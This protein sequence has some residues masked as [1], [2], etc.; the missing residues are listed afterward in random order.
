MAEVEGVNTYRGAKAAAYAIAEKLQRRDEALRELLAYCRTEADNK[1]N[2]NGERSAYE[3]AA[4]RL[5]EILDGK[6]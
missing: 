1:E 6:S 4:A 2:V 3:D 5:A